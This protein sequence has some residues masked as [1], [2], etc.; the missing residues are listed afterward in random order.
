MASIKMGKPH[1]K[2]KVCAHGG[3]WAGKWF[4]T[5]VPDGDRTMYI[6][7]GDF[8]GYYRMNHGFNH[9]ATWEQIE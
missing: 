1:P 5:R 8:K 2:K 7:V 6:N 4:D 3:P 9:T